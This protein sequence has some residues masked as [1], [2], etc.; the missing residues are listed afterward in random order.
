[1]LKG[2]QIGNTELGDKPKGL[3]GLGDCK[4]VCLVRFQT[5]KSFQHFI[6][7]FVSAQSQ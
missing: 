3:A 5:F 1:M 2:Q 7:F 6:N 4:D